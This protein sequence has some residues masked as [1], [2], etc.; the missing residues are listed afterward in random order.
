MKPS[1][2]GDPEQGPFR[3]GAVVRGNT[4]FALDLYRR[5]RVAKGNLFFS[6]YSISTALAMTWAGARE[7]TELQMAQTLHFPSDQQQLHAAFASLEARLRSVQEKGHVRLEVANALW[8]HAGYPFLEAFLALAQEYYGVAITPV[9]YRD[10][11]AA[12]RRINAWVEEKTHDRIRELIPQGVLTVLTRLVLVNAIYF[13]GDWA[14]QFDAA[15]TRDAPFRIAPSEQVQ[16]PT[17]ARKDSFA[18]GEFDDLQILELPYAG[19]DLSMLILLPGKADGLADLEAALTAEN[20]RRWTGNLWETEVEVFLPRFEIGQ[21]FRLDATLAAMGM[22][23]A[24]D[25]DKANFAGMDGNEKWLYIG[26]VL[27]K[28]FVKVNEEG[29]EAAAATAVVMLARGLPMPPPTFRADHPFV[30]LIRERNT[31]TILFLGRVVDPVQ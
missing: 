18:Y 7:H 12:R 25:E 4:A 15:L 27:H 1:A 14:N 5:L 30:F 6:P 29:T 31:S 16:A 26:A 20:L 19:G 10:F 17:M 23:D 3:A 13:K 24:F 22:P 2:Q 28:A 21:G 9:D 11:E 8:P